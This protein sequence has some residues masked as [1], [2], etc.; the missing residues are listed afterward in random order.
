MAVAVGRS[1]KECW[2]DRVTHGGTIPRLTFAHFR[3][4]SGIE[5][6]VVIERPDGRVM[7]IEAKSARSVKQR[8]ASGLTFLRERLGGRFE[9]GILFHTGPITARFR[10]RV[11]AV[12]VAARWGGVSGAKDPLGPQA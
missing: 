12:P 6:D 11:G 10:D 1:C 7:A 3:D 4:R 9:C 2:D 8:D 5:V